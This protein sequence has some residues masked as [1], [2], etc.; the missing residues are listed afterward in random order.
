[1]HGA[2]QFLLAPEVPFRRLNRHVSQEEL[3]LIQF[4]AGEV[5]QTRAGPSQVVRREL[6]D[7][8]AVGVTSSLATASLPSPVA[9]G[10]TPSFAVFEDLSRS[11]LL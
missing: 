8:G 5:A 3:D 10:Q 2:T 9:S 6:I 11:Q 1:V 4:A 7:A